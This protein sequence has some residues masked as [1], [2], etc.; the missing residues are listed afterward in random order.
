M[1]E[2][3]PPSSGAFEGDLTRDHT[4]SPGRRSDL[5]NPTPERVRTI[6]EAVRMRDR[7]LELEARARFLAEAS[8]VLASSLDVDTTLLSVAR[9]AV[10]LLGDW[11]MFDVTAEQGGVRR[12]A[13]AHADP[14]RDAAARA[15]AQLGPGDEAIPC[16]AP[17][18][19]RSGALELTPAVSEADLARVQ[20]PR[21]RAL[22]CELGVRA[23]LCVPLV[24]RGR[25]LGAL[26]CVLGESGREFTPDG[27]A[28]AEDFAQRAAVAVDN[29]RLYREVERASAA[30]S[31]FL[32]VMSHEFRTP[33]H[34]ITGY[35][36]MLRMGL[37]VAIP[38][39]ALAH[40]ERI[41]QASEHLLHL[42]EQLLT[43]SR[44]GA[45]RERVHAEPADVGTLA[46]ELALLVEPL[47]AAKGLQ[48]VVDVPADGLPMV[49]DRGKLRQI[50]Y[51]LLANAVKFTD[52][53]AVTL[54]AQRERG[55]AGESVALDVEDTGIGIAPEHLGTVFDPF[56]QAEPAGAASVAHAVPGEGAAG[57]GGTGL[58]LSISRDLARLLGAE[59]R[60]RST[61]GLGTTFTLVLPVTPPAS[62]GP[63]AP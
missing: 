3:I 52:R 44:L 53:G 36:D 1:T 4:P 24:A 19:L 60:V 43:A 57:R 39:Q 40:V 16:G 22:L 37:P 38:P 56:W 49:T 10:P 31:E 32:A 17:S 59:L 42:V 20:D 51:N 9:L 29:A 54:R 33:L 2:P 13:V 27:V 12:V 46:R 35:A 23:H 48:F 47:A 28:L 45:G 14:H 34:V 18:A 8:R 62:G 11:C 21:R 58:G 6:S 15:L 41:G 25:P 61:A 26:T 7:A 50:L 5:V 55:P 63:S 30:K